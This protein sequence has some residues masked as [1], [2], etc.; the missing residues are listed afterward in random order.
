MVGTQTR[1]RTLICPRE[2]YQDDLLY[3]L[4]PSPPPTQLSTKDSWLS[5]KG[6]QQLHTFPEVM[7]VSSY[8]SAR[9]RPSAI[10]GTRDV[11]DTQ[12]EGRESPPIGWLPV[13]ANM[14]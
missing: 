13:R 5:L 10:F 7:A 2:L 12:E 8:V 9:E 3:P 4:T 14:P 11:T 1:S 6:R